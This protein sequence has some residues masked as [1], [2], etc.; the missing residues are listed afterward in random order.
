MAP[1][2]VAPRPDL[3]EHALLAPHA[4]A[5]EGKELCRAVLMLAYRAPA[6]A[7]K[8]LTC[9]NLG[10]ATAIVHLPGETFIEYQLHCP[11]GAGGA[12]DPSRRTVKSVSILTAACYRPPRAGAEHYGSAISLQKVQNGRT[13]VAEAA[14]PK[15]AV[16]TCT[17]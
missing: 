3:D 14:S 9:L 16:P 11:G 17:W 1:V 2:L 15:S 10:G 7:A 13:R 4:R 6:R 8:P 5:T 12:A